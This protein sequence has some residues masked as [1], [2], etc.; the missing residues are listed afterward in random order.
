VAERDEIGGTR[1]R[2]RRWPATRGTRL[3]TF[4]AM[5]QPPLSRLTGRVWG[6]QLGV[7][8]PPAVGGVVGARRVL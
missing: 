3:L 1:A 4:A 7:L 6:T 8:R 2:R 5:T